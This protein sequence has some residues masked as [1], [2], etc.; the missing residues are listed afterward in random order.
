[1]SAI[2]S[3]MPVVQ[4]SWNDAKAYCD[5]SGKRL[6]TEAEWEKAAR[7]PN[8]NLYPWGNDVPDTSRLNFN[9]HIRTPSDVGSYYAG[10]STYGVFDLSGNAW[11]WVADW[12]KDNYYS[13]SPGRN[14]T[15][16]PTGQYKI[17]RGGG[18]SS[19]VEMVRSAYRYPVAPE[20]TRD[21]YGF[22]CASY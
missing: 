18:W 9:H 11:E 17:L 7:G 19:Q 1:M 6:P 20:A 16:P 22:R 21:D 13:I 15:G 3:K 10:I 14:P 12:Y 4:I 8:G 2:L 5:W